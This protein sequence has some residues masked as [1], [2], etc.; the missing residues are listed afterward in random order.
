M[1]R[2]LGKQPYY[3]KCIIAR[4]VRYYSTVTGKCLIFLHFC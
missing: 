2:I 4:L 1:P 3:V